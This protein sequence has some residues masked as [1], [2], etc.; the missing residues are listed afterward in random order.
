MDGYLYIVVLGSSTTQ[1]GT[2][3]IVANISTNIGC[4]KY[5]INIEQ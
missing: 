5:T 3:P 2:R 4:C 1:P